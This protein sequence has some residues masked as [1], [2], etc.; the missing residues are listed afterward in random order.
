MLV[1]TLTPS[2]FVELPFDDWIYVRFLFVL[3]C[4]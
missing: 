2:T 4:L 3:L 1:T